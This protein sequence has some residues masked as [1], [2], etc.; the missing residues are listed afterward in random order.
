ME[1]LKPTVE[2]DYLVV[3]RWASKEAFEAWVGSPEF[4]EGHKRGFAD[5]AEAK[6]RGEESPMKS[7]FKTYT[8]LTT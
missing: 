2:G 7:T 5:I 3:S 4:V 8:V 1:V 6:R